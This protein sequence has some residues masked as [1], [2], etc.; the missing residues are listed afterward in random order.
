[1]HHC[2]QVVLNKSSK[3][4]GEIVD[5]AEY[6][7]WSSGWVQGITKPADTAYLNTRLDRA[8]VDLN[9]FGWLIGWV[10]ECYEKGYL[11]KEQLD[12]IEP[13]WGDMEASV[14]LLQKINKREGIGNLLAEGVKRASEKIGGPAA[15]CAIYTLKG[16]TPRGHDHRARWEELLDTC[17]G[18]GGTI[19]TG[20]AVEPGEQGRPA[21]I[22]P[23]DPVE[24]PKNVAGLLG[25]RHF[26]DCLGSCLFTT[27]TKLANI[28]LAVNAVTGWD[29][30]VPE[31]IRVG[32][33]VSV[34]M[35]AFN[36]RC[37]IG[38]ELERPSKRYGSIPVD[39]PAAGKASAPHWDDMLNL[40]YDVARYDRKTGR[41]M[42]ELLHEL[43]LEQVSKDLWGAT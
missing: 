16:N 15:D 37:G 21:R 33:R 40:Y 9:E 25:R 24:V 1:M 23:Q 30:D 19:E 14:A 39:G 32:K 11:T 31:A 12:G 3:Y 22:N 10:M 35:R 6:E 17:V 7:G 20:P 26:E 4:A 42:P 29:M 8:C 2:H 5:E 18:S 36:L 38:P 34:L 28:C 13:R 41:P 27:R 43:G